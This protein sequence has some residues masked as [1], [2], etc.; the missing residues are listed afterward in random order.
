MSKYKKIKYQ[1]ETEAGWYAIKEFISALLCSYK[2]DN[3]TIPYN[4][5]EVLNHHFSKTGVFNPYRY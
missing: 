5:N 2:I 1:P 4:T 3:G